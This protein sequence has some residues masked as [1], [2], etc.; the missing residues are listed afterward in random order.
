MKRIITIISS[1][2]IALMS[3]T[4]C[5]I[6]WIDNSGSADAILTCYYAGGMPSSSATQTYELYDIHLSDFE[7]E[8]I[9]VELQQVVRPGFL[10]A[11]LEIHFY[12]NYDHYRKTRIFDFWWETTNPITGDGY[13]AWD[14]IRE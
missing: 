5:H 6:E 2:I 11:I 14:E 12:D 7:I 10:E 4:S 9:F 3:F 13:Y 1:G 8:E